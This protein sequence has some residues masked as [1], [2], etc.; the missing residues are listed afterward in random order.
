MTTVIRPTRTQPETAPEGFVPCLVADTDVPYCRHSGCTY[1]H[2]NPVSYF[3]RRSEK[4]KGRKDFTYFEMHL[5]PDRKNHWLLPVNPY[6]KSTP[7]RNRFELFRQGSGEV[8]IIG[9][10]PKGRDIFHRDEISF[11]Y[12]AEVK[13]YGDMY[14]SALEQMDHEEV[15][16]VA[17]YNGLYK[18]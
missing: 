1:L 15:N 2:K 7:E 3:E 16:E 12:I 5:S 8:R 14:W 6:R 17:Y 18:K 9:H 13:G 4:I 11:K 10:T